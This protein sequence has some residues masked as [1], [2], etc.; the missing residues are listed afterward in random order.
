MTGRLAV[1]D[2]GKSYK[3]YRSEW[4]RVG[5]WFGLPVRAKSENWVLSDVSFTVEPGEALAII[6]QNGA[7]KST[8]LKLI[9]GTLRPSTGYITYDGR[10]SA[11]LELG[12]GFNPDLTGRQ[13]AMQSAKLMGFS[14]DQIEAVMPE[15][16]SFS[17]VGSYF[18]QP[19]R[20]YS[21]GMQ[22][23]VAFAVATAFR[24]D[25]LIVDEALSV[26]DAYFQHK[27]FD[28]IRRFKA[29]GTTLLFV[30]HSIGDVR[31]ICDRAILLAGGRVLKDGLPDEVADYY[32]ALLAM[33][34]NEQSNVEQNRTEEGW[35]VTRSGS[36]EARVN[37]L[38]LIDAKE[39]AVL[40]VVQVG[41]QVSL[42]AYVEIKTA[43]TKLIVGF[44]IRDRAGTVVW[45]SN[46]HYTHQAITNAA[47][48]TTWQVEFTFNCELGPGT[49]SVSPA[50]ADSETH[51]S[52]N[53]EWIDNMLFFEVV[54]LGKPTFIGITHLDGTFAIQGPLVKPHG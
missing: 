20:T 47:T 34:E 22:M 2:L 30:S 32:N 41:Q 6:G 31:T 42:R 49:Y 44:M 28:R 14:T 19:V 48:G 10:I 26:G 17:E 50:L 37:S 52:R 24:P 1:K 7:G 12:M 15:I 40:K 4:Q 16:L 38:E 21:S 11:I 53:F 36:G 23:R 46:T 8:L 54:N 9:T 43:V 18:E 27:S 35:L 25:I 29:L 39:G 13:N 3:S 51:T 45:G 33:K 5:G